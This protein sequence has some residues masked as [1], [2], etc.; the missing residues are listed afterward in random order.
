MSSITV[1]IGLSDLKRTPYTGNPYVGWFE[2]QIVH[3][4]Q[5]AG[6]PVLSNLCGR[7]VGIASGNLTRENNP[8]N[9][10]MI[11]AWESPNEGPE[12]GE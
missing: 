9:G 3:L 7:F 2:M 1:E 5:K 4:L 10:K 6:M 8:N 11:F 12:V